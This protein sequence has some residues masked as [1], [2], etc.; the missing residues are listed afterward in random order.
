MAMRELARHAEDCGVRLAVQPLNRFY[1]TLINTTEQGLAYCDEVGSPAVGL[2][3]STYHMHYE[4][5]DSGAAIRKAARRLLHLHAAENDHGVPGSG[6]VHWASVFQALR[7][8]GY[9]GAVVVESYA[10][11]EPAAAHPA[12]I[13]RRVAPDQDAVAVDGLAFLRQGLGQ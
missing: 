12:H 5:K 2:H 9:S 13:W 7:A 6:Q 4:E 1:S 8:V 3:L 10:P 11:Y